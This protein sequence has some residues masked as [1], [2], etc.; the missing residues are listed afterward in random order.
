MPPSSDPAVAEL[1]AA[2]LMRQNQRILDHDPTLL[3][4]H[5]PG[6][7]KPASR[8]KS[9]KIWKPF[10]LSLSENGDENNSSFD[11]SGKANPFDVHAKIFEP[12]S[13]DGSG[14]ADA[15]CVASR[16]RSTMSISEPDD[17]DFQLVRSRKTKPSARHMLGLNAYEVKTE[18][19]PLTVTAS[20]NKKEINE[21][22]GN[23]LP[24]PE[25][26]QSICGSQHGQL[27]FVVHPNGDVSAHQWSTEKYQ[28]MN[29]GQFSNIRKRREGMLASLRLRDETE[30]HTKQ[31]N[32]LAY[33]RAVAKQLEASIMSLP[34]GAREIQAA[35]PNIR[36]YG[37][38]SSG[39][40][41]IAHKKM[42]ASEI[43]MQTG[44]LTADYASSG[45]ASENRFHPHVNN[46][47]HYFNLLETLPDGISREEL[48]RLQRAICSPALEKEDRQSRKALYRLH[49][50]FENLILSD[51]PGASNVSINISNMASASNGLSF[52]SFPATESG[53]SFKHTSLS[54]QPIR[55]TQQACTM[56]YST[57]TNHESH[58]SIT[59]RSS[60]QVRQTGGSPRTSHACP[61]NYL[62]GDRDT[63]V[64]TGNASK[65]A[66]EASVA[67]NALYTPQR[68]GSIADGRK[69]TK[70]Y[71][72]KLGSA[73]SARGM[74]TIATPR[75]VMHDPL[76]IQIGTNLQETARYRAK[77]GLTPGGPA[78][79]ETSNCSLSVPAHMDT[80]SPFLYRQASRDLS[81]SE[82]EPGWKDRPVEV[83][84]IST[85]HMSH[86]Q[87][88][89]Y[90]RPTPQNWS[91][92]F[93]TGSP[94]G[95]TANRKDYEEE[96]HKWF[97][98]GR[99]AQHQED[100][101]QR[102]KA[103]HMPALFS[104]ARRQDPGVIGRP[105]SAAAKK[106]SESGDFNDIT[107]RLLIPVLE[108]LSSYVQGPVEQRHGYFAP[109]TAPPEWCVDKSP[110]GNSSF[111]G[112]DWGQPPERIGRDARYGHAPFE[113]RFGGFSP[114]RP[115]SNGLIGLGVGA[116]P[117][118]GR[119]RFGS[120]GTKF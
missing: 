101:F 53:N 29:I 110:S 93:F 90:S 120:T 38:S 27:Q 39:T 66:H 88:A 77:T 98:N 8:T 108:N 51:D 7:A 96:L 59:Q 75:T 115:T 45:V 14:H 1:A 71:L 31:Q 12:N 37:T 112:E 16:P 48:C 47:Y 35:M 56:P 3:N 67:T 23:D 79:K 74:G 69:I 24:P 62:T 9:S 97:S 89:L 100:F 5:I 103:A 54:P 61:S 84:D 72:E 26:V 92:P 78:C 17:S 95:S 105:Y 109:F 50:P 102:V 44:N 106:N 40:S 36:V 65:P 34:W 42:N 68:P 15:S 43:E 55:Q 73:A 4:T 83:I 20:F 11:I 111:F 41:S 114:Q 76:K 64:S 46:A 99:K 19:K 57:K 60:Q 81:N 28:W 119:F 22:F 104:P 87:L 6:K 10:S 58:N 116:Q 32:T 91:G 49:T 21:V 85:P 30:E 86:E 13:R 70:E 63:C 33:F 52:V 82:P 2:K 113:G 117:L 25:Y 107:T 18:D 80:G 118:D 94:K